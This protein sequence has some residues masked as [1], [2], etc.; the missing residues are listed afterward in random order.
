MSSD[1]L[2]DEVRIDL[3]ARLDGELDAAAER[4]LED[5]LATC[6]ECRSYAERLRQV[7]SA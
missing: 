3:S 5:H 1:H 2:H 4:R 7:R 6:S